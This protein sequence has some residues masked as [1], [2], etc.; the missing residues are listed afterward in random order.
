LLS[1]NVDDLADVVRVVGA[2]VGKTPGRTPSFASSAVSNPFFE[3]VHHFAELSYRFIPGLA[4]K[5]A[6]LLVIIP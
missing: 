4:I 2:D 5:L 1:A 3:F 6:E